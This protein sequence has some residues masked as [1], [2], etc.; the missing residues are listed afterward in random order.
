MP[1]LLYADFRDSNRACAILIERVCREQ[2][3]QLGYRARVFRILRQIESF[4]RVGVMIVELDAQ[5]AAVPFS[6]TI[7][8]G[9][10]RSPV[11]TFF[12][13]SVFAAH[14]LCDR[15]FGPRTLRAI[16]EWGK[17]GAFQAF[18]EWKPAQFR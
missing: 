6:I 11:D 13:G 1:I 18:R 14:H 17:A 7:A 3:P 10:Y 15:R 16:E 2:P 5:F 12:N 9:A 8:L 4:I